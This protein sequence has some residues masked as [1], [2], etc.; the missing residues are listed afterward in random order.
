M[1]DRQQRVAVILETRKDQFIE[2]IM[3][4]NDYFGGWVNPLLTTWI[5]K[6]GLSMALHNRITVGSVLEAVESFH[7]FAEDLRLIM[8]YVIESKESRIEDIGNF[9]KD[10]S[11]FV[12]TSYQLITAG[13]S[14]VDWDGINRPHPIGFIPVDDNWRDALKEIKSL[15]TISDKAK[16]FCELLKHTERGRSLLNHFIGLLPQDKQDEPQHLSDA[17]PIQ[18]N[19][20]TIV[21]TKPCG[22]EW[23]SKFLAE[24]IS[25]EQDRQSCLVVVDNFE[26][27][28]VEV[29]KM[30]IDLEVPETKRRRFF[31]EIQQTDESLP[32]E[33]ELLLSE[34]P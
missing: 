26:K 9:I 12:F 3:K 1:D 27:R 25:N 11:D 8:A 34:Q 30:L 15:K 31:Q 28:L 7:Y 6:Q 24:I 20:L 29:R 22:L 13:T 19:N 4:L 5:G 10:L 32:K 33:T 16:R 23:S 2:S 18:D 17:D 14:A 21:P